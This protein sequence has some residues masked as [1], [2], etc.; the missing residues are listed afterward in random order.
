M[1][2]FK[3][4]LLE[5]DD[6]HIR[7]AIAQLEKEGKEITPQAIADKLDV[8]VADVKRAAK[9]LS[10]VFPEIARAFNTIH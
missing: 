6:M 10:I 8:E 7:D 2:T 9:P 4:Y 1:M 3:D 5:Q